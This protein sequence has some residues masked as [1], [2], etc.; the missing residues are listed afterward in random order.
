MRGPGMRHHGTVSKHGKVAPFSE[1]VEALK[2]SRPPETTVQP[3]PGL[4]DETLVD[5]RGEAYEVRRDRLTP[6]E[7]LELAAAGALVVWDSCSCGGQCG[8]QWFG[9]DEVRRMVLSGEP[10]IR[11]KNYWE[12]IWEMRSA[13][14]SCILLVFGDVRWGDILR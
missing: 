13:T 6:A 8:L 5:Q 2:A 7:A 11:R 10:R 14:D 4:H 9:R 12:E 1:V 3:A